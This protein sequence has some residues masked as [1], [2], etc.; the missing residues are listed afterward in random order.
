MVHFDHQPVG[1]GGHRSPTHG[2]YLVAAAAS[3]TW[4]NYDRKMC[5]FLYHRYGTEIQGVARVVGESSDTTLAQN[6]IGVS[7]GHDVFSG[8]KPFLDC[9]SHTALEKNWFLCLAGP[10]KQR[11]VL[12]ISSTNLNDISVFLHKVTALV[13]QCFGNNVQ[14]SFLPDSGQYL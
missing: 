11:E 4:V 7:F 8:H 3:V 14:T 2:D 5:L 13:I 10:V 1:T 12:H 9:G 6:Y